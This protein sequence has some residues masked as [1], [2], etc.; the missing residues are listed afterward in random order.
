[1]R[2]AFILLLLLTSTAFTQN[3]PD[4][5]PVPSESELAAAHEIINE[6]FGDQIKASK[7]AK[8]KE[9][10]AITLITTSATTSDLLEK[11]AL[12]QQAQKLA[13]EAN[14]LQIYFRVIDAM[15][16]TF[17]VDKVDLWSKQLIKSMEGQTNETTIRKLAEADFSAFSDSTKRNSATDVWYDFSENLKGIPA[18]IARE[19]AVL[20]YRSAIPHLTGLDK[21][22]AEKRLK[23]CMNNVTS[24]KE[25]LQTSSTP[26]TARYGQGRIIEADCTKGLSTLKA[27]K[28]QRNAAKAYGAPLEVTNKI[29]MHFR[30]IPAGTFVMGSPK[31]EPYRNQE[32]EDQH[33]VKITEPFYI[34]VTEV[35][36]SQYWQITGQNPSHFPNRANNPV[37]QA[38][39]DAAQVFCEKISKLDRERTYQLPTAEQWEYACRAGMTGAT[40]GPLDQIAWYR[41]TSN[42]STQPVA[43]RAPNA[44]GLYDCIGNVWE[45]CRDQKDSSAIIRGGCWNDTLSDLSLRSSGWRYWSRNDPENT[46]GFRVMF[47]LK[48]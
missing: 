22:R 14:D 37:E 25:L 13:L 41:K 36:Q 19:R 40:Y 18:Q 29:G 9:E 20:H 33:V 31:G 46:V 38:T 10:L 12:L 32:G 2:Y 17:Q 43:L 16:E 47:T 11:Y 30:F 7:D 28:A 26:Q 15:G 27:Q 24:S 48:P 45:F 44:W 23:E 21:L 1:M 39:W 4:R 3:T 8:S 34:G 42:G 5:S 6:V 35:T